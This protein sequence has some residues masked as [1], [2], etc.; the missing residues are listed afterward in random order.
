MYSF[1]HFTLT[2]F[3]LII[4]GGKLF[5]HLVYPIPDKEK[6]VL[7]IHSTIDLS[8]Q[9]KFGP[10]AVWV[11]PKES[12][13]FNGQT[14]DLRVENTEEKRI[15]FFQ[16]IQKYYPNIKIE[17]IS[18]DYCGIR[19]KLFGPNHVGPLIDKYGRNLMDFMIEGP[20]HHGIYGLVNLYGIESP[21]LTSSLAI[22]DYVQQLLGLKVENNE[23]CS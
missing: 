20:Q 7:G 14:C 21:G 18:P 16:S 3:I 11:K 2:N 13:P 19:P 6:N 17:D 1:I 8:G 22:A 12:D 5:K 15:M 10:D 9:T 23:D 4:I